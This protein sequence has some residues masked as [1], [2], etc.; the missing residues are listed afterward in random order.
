MRRK[1]ESA[2]R[3]IEGARRR[4]EDARHGT[5]DEKHRVFLAYLEKR[6]I[7]Y[8]DAIEARLPVRN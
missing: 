8:K 6:A 1:A 2:R 4:T 3:K 5:E 7:E